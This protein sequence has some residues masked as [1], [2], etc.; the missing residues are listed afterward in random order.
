MSDVPSFH[1]VVIAPTFD[2]ARTLS[3]VITRIGELG[4]PIIVVDDGCRDGSAEILRSL[5]IPAER[6]TVLTHPI[7]RGKA[8]ALQTGFAHAAS[9]GFTHAVTI[10]TDGQLDPVQIPDLLRIA[11]SAPAAL[12]VGRRDASAPGYPAASRAGR[13]WSNLGV[14]WESGLRV[15]DSQCGFRVYPLRATLSLRCRAGRYGFETEI[16]TRAAWAGVPVVETPVTCVY[17]LPDGR[18]THFRRW[19]DSLAGVGM[20]ARLMIRSCA[21][22]GVRR[23]ESEFISPVLGGE[24]VEPGCALNLPLAVSRHATAK[25]QA[26]DQTHNRVPQPDAALNHR[27]TGTIWARFL[28]WISPIRAWREMRQ[29]PRERSRFAAGFAVGV[30][31]ANLPLY[32][33]QTLLSLYAARRLRLNPL[34]VVAGSHLS[35]PPV[36]PLLV[37]AAIALGHW[38]THGRLPALRAHDPSKIGYLGLV[39]SVLLEWIIGGVICGAILAGAAFFII[40]ALLRLLPA[41]TAQAPENPP[42]RPAPSLD[43]AAPKPAA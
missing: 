1:P 27:A 35:T 37:A 26:E 9:A 38:V 25:P 21:P 39:R 19:R 24:D 29:D 28:R 11:R 36:G 43:R 6:C 31:I 33:V 41:R 16:L 8:A 2:N 12:V 42:A 3:G 34:P 17:D 22:W 23:V 5:A 7:N 4:L 13:F 20:H 40:A 30:F 10:D 32:G 18:V 14:R 15:S